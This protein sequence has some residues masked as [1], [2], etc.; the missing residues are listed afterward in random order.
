[1]HNSSFRALT[2]IVI[3]AF[4]FSCS[5]T[6][7]LPQVTGDIKSLNLLSVYEIP[8]NQKYKNTV[9]GG[10][11]GIDYDV[12][13][14]LYYM[15]S[16]DRSEKNPARFYTAKIFITQKGID[17]IAFTDVNYMLQ[18]GGEVYPDSKTLY[19]SVEEPLYEDGPRADIVDNNAFIRIIKFDVI[20]KKSVAQFAYK[21]DP[22]A[23]ASK[24]ETEFKVNGVP[25]ILNLGNNKLLV[26]ERSF[27]TGR[28]A[29][30]IKVFI[31]DLNNATDISSTALKDNRSFTLAKKLL[32]LNMDDL[33]IY[34]DNIEGVTFGPVLPNGHK[35]LLFIAD[36]NFNMLEKAQILL[37]EVLED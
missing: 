24:S 10:L 8:F 33:G 26:I 20:A 4:S 14:D 22:V 21:L 11:S 19:V 23:Y 30:T 27:S 9:V 15:V 29:C 18:P 32:L 13:K 34:T 3:T 37:F 36:N 25:D 7:R 2:F 1:M 6:K 5:Y 17:S 12:N 28:I 16:D 35:T 31:A